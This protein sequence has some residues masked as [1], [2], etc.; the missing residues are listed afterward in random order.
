MKARHRSILKTL[1]SAPTAPFRERAVIDAV[2]DW[3]QRRGAAIA[4]DEALAKRL[5]HLLA[6]RG[7]HLRGGP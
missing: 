7:K 5:D 3:A 4:A 2:A 6:T 1:L